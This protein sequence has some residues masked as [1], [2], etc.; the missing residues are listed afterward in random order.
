MTITVRLPEELERELQ[1]HLQVS[2]QRISDFVRQ[3]IAE[4]L[5]REPSA[6]PSAYERGQ[7]LFG[8]YGSG[9]GNLSEKA[10]EIV[11]EKIHAKHRG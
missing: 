2:S 8:R 6:K 9:R 7:H 5:G 11:R 4:K 3:A 1:A 10:D